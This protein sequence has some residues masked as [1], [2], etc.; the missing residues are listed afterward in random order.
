MKAAQI[1]E[2]GGIDQI[3]LAD[4]DKPNLAKGLVLVEVHAASIN[5]FDTTAREGKARSMKQLDMPATL[6][7]DIAGIVAEVGS[8]VD[9]FSV[10]DKVYGQASLFGGGSGA[11][12]EFA[13]TPAKQIAK[14]P[15]GIGFEQ[16]A[17]LPLTGVAA[18][19]ALTEHLEL[20]P[21]Q[22][23]IIQGGSGGIGTVAI[24]L[25]KHIGAYVAV[26]VSPKGIEYAKQLGADKIID[27]KSQDFSELVHGFDAVLDLVGGEV[28]EKSIDCLRAGGKA[29][30]TVSEADKQHAKDKNIEAIYQG[31]VVNTDKLNKLRELVEQGVIKENVDKTFPLSQIREA[32]MARESGD[33]LGKVIV[34]V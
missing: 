18:L 2:Y 33:T 28:L 22:K 19:Q 11:F 4:T 24:Q 31:T 26:T 27:Y 20:Q 29:V 3:K 12:A 5:P 6:G 16:A 34:K 10:G 25:A 14:M 21:N 15:G 8:D 17:A 13:A 32:F 23:L 7:G 9:D 30:S 1:Y